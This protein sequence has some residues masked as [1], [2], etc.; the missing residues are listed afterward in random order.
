MGF[1]ALSYTE[2]A[3]YL[4]ALPEGVLAAVAAVGSY[5]YSD[6]RI[7]F[8]K[9]GGVLYFRGGVA[10]YVVYLVALAA[11]LALDSLF[12]GPAAFDAGTTVALSGAPLLSTMAT[13]LLLTFGVGLLLGRAVRLA[14]R[15][16]KIA[17]GV[18]IPASQLP[19]QK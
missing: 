17:A 12:L 16:A 14:K 8:W 13:D 10:I 1:S 9:E 4:L 11:R 5:L 18:E 7:T 3:P 15:Y 6:R 19:A 2:G